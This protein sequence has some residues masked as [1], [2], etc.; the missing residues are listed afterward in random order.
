MEE[1]EGDAAEL[2]EELQQA[3]DIEGVLYASLDSP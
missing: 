1:E 3:Q 2:D